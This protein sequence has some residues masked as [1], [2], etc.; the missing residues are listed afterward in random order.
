MWPTGD[1]EPEE[2]PIEWRESTLEELIEKYLRL[3]DSFDASN[4]FIV[5]SN[6][7]FGKLNHIERIILSKT[8]KTKREKFLYKQFLQAR[9]TIDMMINPD[10][11]KVAPRPAHTLPPVRPFRIEPIIAAV[12]K[13]KD[14]KNK[15]K[16]RSVLIISRSDTTGFTAKRVVNQNLE[17]LPGPSQA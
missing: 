2:T 3:A 9:R 12:Y 6:V 13:V 17:E 7:K 8:P 5:E 1:I 4:I 14:D 15:K 11:F 10:K 16:Y